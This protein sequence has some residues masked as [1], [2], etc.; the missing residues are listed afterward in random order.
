MQ[1]HIN[2][3]G[4]YPTPPKQKTHKDPWHPLSP[5]TT[6]TKYKFPRR[7]LKCQQSNGDVADVIDQIWPWPLAK[8][9]DVHFWSLVSA[10]HPLP[11]CLRFSWQLNGQ[12]RYLKVIRKPAETTTRC[13]AKV[14]I[15]TV[16][17][18]IPLLNMIFMLSWRFGLRGQPNTL[19]VQ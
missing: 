19:I 13:P 12:V 15:F 17:V 1:I 2:H 7:Q 3:N 10:I 5:I 16:V 14:V 18:V 8:Y 9:C 4:W 6:L 11:L